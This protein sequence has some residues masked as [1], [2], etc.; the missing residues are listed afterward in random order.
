MKRKIPLGI[1][2]Q[3]ETFDT[4][5]EKEDSAW[6]TSTNRNLWYKGWD[7]EPWMRW[8]NVRFRLRVSS[9]CQYIVH[10]PA[11]TRDAA[12]YKLL[13]VQRNVRF[14]KFSVFAFQ[15][16]FL[17]SFFLNKYLHF[18]TN[19]N[20][21]EFKPSV[22]TLTYNRYDDCFSLKYRTQRLTSKRRL[23]VSQGGLVLHHPGGGGWVGAR[24]GE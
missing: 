11:I 2:L 1:F 14:R 18:S 24:G 10:S 20:F 9:H 17:I 7:E 15:Q 22:R 3:T 19:A 16:L 21:K 23:C 4:R 6:C 13:I 12:K 8:C 5:D